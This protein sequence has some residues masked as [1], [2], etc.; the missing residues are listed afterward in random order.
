MT[1]LFKIKNLFHQSFTCENLQAKIFPKVTGT[2][3]TNLRE[4]EKREFIYVGTLSKS[5]AA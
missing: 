1:N 5:I 2:H 3:T 4:E